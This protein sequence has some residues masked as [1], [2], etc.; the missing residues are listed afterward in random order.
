MWNNKIQGAQ[1]AIYCAPEYNVLTFLTNRPGWLSLFLIRPKYH[2]IGIA[3]CVW[4]LLLVKFR[5]IPF[6]GFRGEVEN[7][8]AKQRSGWLS[9]L[10]EKHI[11]G[12]GR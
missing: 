1:K 9:D 12:L 3:H 10:P 4:Y 11:F 8:S 7:V 6:S 5:Q 2:K